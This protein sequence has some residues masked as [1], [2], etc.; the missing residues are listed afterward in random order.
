M[1]ILP[2]IDIKDGKVVRLRQG[3]FEQMT[4]FSN[5]PVDMARKWQEE[6][7]T[8]LHVVDLDGSVS[9]HPINTDVVLQI[10]QAVGLHV[11]VGGGLRGVDDIA[12]LI[13][14]GIDRVVLGT[15][16]IHNPALVRDLVEIWGEKIVVAL[17]AR[18]GQV[19]TQGWTVGSQRTTEEMAAEMAAV[20]VRRLLCTAINRDGMLQGPDLAGLAAIQRAAG[21]EVGVI[22]SGGIASLDDLIALRDQGLEGAIIGSALYTGAIKLSAA[23]KAV[24]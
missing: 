13:G 6:G 15:A 16:A 12:H 22:A 23:I 14:Q 11:Q 20:G 10:R 8:W 2:S 21:P 3:D 24:Q 18:D 4:V 1:Y 5:N 17:D 19:A 9:G 7:A